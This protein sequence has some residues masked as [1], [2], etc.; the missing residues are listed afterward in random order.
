M[1]IFEGRVCFN[2]KTT[3]CEGDCVG[4]SFDTSLN[5]YSG[6][7]PSTD[8]ID[9]YI[10]TSSN[11]TDFIDSLKEQTK[12]KITIEKIKIKNKNK[13]NKNKNNKNK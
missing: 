11:N 13:N 3:A 7:D 2:G 10:T 6:T 8:W 5:R 9:L 12:Y 4:L 1:P